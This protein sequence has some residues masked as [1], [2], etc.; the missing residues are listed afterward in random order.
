VLLDADLASLY[1]TPTKA[2]NQAVRRNIKRFP[3]DFCFRL[4]GAEFDALNRSQFVTSS[5]KH[6]SARHPPMAFTEHGAIMAANVLNNVRAVEM[7]VHVVRAF[8][9]LRRLV[10]SN[11]ELA[12][13]LDEL[14]RSI[15]L[16]DARTRKQFDEVYRAIKAL[17]LPSASPSKPI[18]FTALIE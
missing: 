15:K 6:R 7:A 4:S 18:G 2:L 14:E 12:R 3:A 8:V 17:M 11:L 1:G 9:G 5:Q 10:T 13:K 16:L